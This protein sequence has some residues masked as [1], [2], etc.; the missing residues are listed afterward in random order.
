MLALLRNRRNKP[1][2]L[3]LYMT[4]IV[5]VPKEKP[6]YMLCSRDVESSFNWCRNLGHIPVLH[7]QAENQIKRTVRHSNMLKKSHFVINTKLIG[8]RYKQRILTRTNLKYILLLTNNLERGWGEWGVRRVGAGKNLVEDSLSLQ[9][10]ALCIFVGHLNSNV[11]AVSS[12]R[13][14]IR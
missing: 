4:I 8:K 9:N 1:C 10:N 14:N 2:I 7:Q 13:C 3:G 5:L 6:C 11:S 12:A